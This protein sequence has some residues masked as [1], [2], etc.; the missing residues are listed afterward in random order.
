MVL[1]IEY[2]GERALSI[3]CVEKMCEFLKILYINNKLFIIT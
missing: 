2:S 3:M 1:F